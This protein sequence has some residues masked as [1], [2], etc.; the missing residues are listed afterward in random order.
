MN[1]L[2]SLFPN[3]FLSSNKTFLWSLEKKNPCNASPLRDRLR[4]EKKERQ[5]LDRGGTT[6]TLK[7]PGHADMLARDFPFS[8]KSSAAV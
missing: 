6:E 4:E 5:K 8:V 3:E 2:L 7:A 1:R